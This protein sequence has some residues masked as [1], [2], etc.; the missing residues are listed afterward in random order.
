MAHQFLGS[1]S[2]YLPGL[3]KTHNIVLNGAYQARDT[4]GKYFFTSSFLLVFSVFSL[5]RALLAS[6]DKRVI[7]SLE[8]ER[9]LF[10]QK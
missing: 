1:G 7:D 4:A 2:F 5:P 3:A 6:A 10:G 8:E 9:N